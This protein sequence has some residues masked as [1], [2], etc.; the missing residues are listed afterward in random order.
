[1]LNLN[2]R[3][4]W[5]MQEH[6]LS[7]SGIAKLAGVKQPS[8]NAWVKGAVKNIRLDAAIKLSKAL[9]VS[10]VWLTQG[11]GEPTDPDSEA[12]ANIR[13]YIPNE[14][15][16]PVG[17][18]AVPEYQ[19]TLRAT[20][21]EGTEPEW[22]ETSESVPVWLPDTFF[23]KHGVKPS[24]CKV[25]RVM[26]DSMEPYIFDKDKVVWVSELDPRPGCVNIRDGSVYVISIDG[27]MKVKRLSKVKG[28]ILVASDNEA[29]YRPEEFIGDE[30]ESIRIYGRILRIIR[31]T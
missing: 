4:N 28:G 9:N 22:E 20:P 5:L 14:E 23:L 29:K 19:L 31:D 10:F 15:R 3:I 16:P 26:G 25:A 2:E 13:Q 12:T 11:K 7:Q 1:M 18:T 17:W 27:N 30:T 21:G 8:V 24:R 6:H